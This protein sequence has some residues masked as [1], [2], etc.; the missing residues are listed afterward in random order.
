MSDSVSFFF[1]RF[2]L[3]IKLWPPE[4]W[5]E[6]ESEWKVINETLVASY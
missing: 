3:L 2:F 1:Y 6:E 4:M 5:I